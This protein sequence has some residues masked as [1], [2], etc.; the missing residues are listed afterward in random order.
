MAPA[1]DDHVGSG[2]GH[3]AHEVA[4]DEHGPALAGQ[5]LH[6]RAHPQDAFGVEA[7]D[8]LVEKQHA[9]VAQQGAGDAE[10]LGHAEGEGPRLPPGHVAEAYEIE[11][12]VDPLAGYVAGLR[13][14]QKVVAGLATG[15]VGLGVE[16]SSHLPHRSAQLLVRH[17]VDRGRALIRVGQAEDQAQGG[18]LAG[19]IG[20]GNPSRPLVAPR[21]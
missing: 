13:Q 5:R 1:Y 2:D 20:P 18:R 6:Q 12:L 17:A 4:R 21:N 3:L 19:P 16:K 15:V 11:H 10:T 7:I 9:G 8:G 14:G